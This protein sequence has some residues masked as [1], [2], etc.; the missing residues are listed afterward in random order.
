MSNLPNRPNSVPNTAQWDTSTG[1]WK[2][3]EEKG[4]KQIGLWKWWRR[5]GELYMEVEY[6]E[7]GER[8]GIRK[9]YHTNGEVYD[10]RKYENGL[11]TGERVFQR[12][13]G[14]TD[15][16]FLRNMHWRVWKVVYEYEDGKFAEANYFQRNGSPIVLRPKEVPRNSY[17]NNYRGTWRSGEMNDNDAEMGLWKTYNNKGFMLSEENYTDG[18]KNGAYKLFHTNGTVAQEGNYRADKQHGTITHYRSN[19]RTSIRFPYEAKQEVSKVVQE[20]EDGRIRSSQYFNKEGVETNRHGTPIPDFNIDKSF[21]SNPSDFLKEKEL[22]TILE[23]TQGDEVVFDI[24]KLNKKFRD[25]WGVD[26]PEELQ[27]VIYN[28]G[29]YNFPKWL[30]WQTHPVKV[31]GQEDEDFNIVEEAILSA[32]NIFPADHFLE[33]F[34]GTV[35]LDDLKG[36]GYRENFSL[37]YGLYD[38]N[39]NPDNKN[40]IYLNEY[41]NPNYS[42]GNGLKK[43]A[44]KD[45]SSLIYLLGGAYAYEVA[46]IVTTQKFSQTIFENSKSN[47]SLTGNSLSDVQINGGRLNEYQLRCTVIQGPALEFFQRAKWIIELLQ[48]NYERKPNV[49]NLINK[50]V[51]VKITDELHQKNLSLVKEV[52]PEALYWLFRT[53]FFREEEYLNAYLE[54]A[55]TSPSRVVRDTGKLVEELK[56][57]RQRLGDIL[58]VQEFRSEYLK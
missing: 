33:W 43:V 17:Y 30:F 25:L 23:K 2:H 46:S 32:Q 9:I 53:F 39:S 1:Y 3:G 37:H 50:N 47:V 10:N 42:W 21:G 11:P 49:K 20:F 57:G 41:R 51:N 6:N 15:L 16:G 58:N 31:A 55:K 52:V 48:Y 4:G 5:G 54:A 29:K 14:R 56:N 35:C 27:D 13:T 24:K 19:E 8:H 34:T 18:Q 7:K 36:G 28:F 38:Y 44:A 45:L 12:C 22:E 26:M 40:Y